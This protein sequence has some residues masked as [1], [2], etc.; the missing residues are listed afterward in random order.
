MGTAHVQLE[1]PVHDAIQAL[2]GLIRRKLGEEYIDQIELLQL[3]KEPQSNDMARID[4]HQGRIRIAGTSATSMGYALHKYL[5]ENVHIHLDWDN[6]TLPLP[7]KLPDV[8]QTI[9]LKKTSKVTYYLNVCTPSYSMWS[10]NWAHWEAHIDWMVLCGIN[11]PL[12]IVGQEKLWI[13]TFKKFGVGE[14]ELNEFIAGAAFLAWGRM[15][16]IQGSW[17]PF[18]TV[19]MHWIEAQ[20]KLQLLIL[21]RMRSFGMLPALPAFAGHVPAALKHLYPHASMRKA[22]QWAGF[23]EKYTCVYMLDPTDSLFHSIATTFLSLQREFY[24]DYTSS[25]YQT[26]MYNELLPHTSDVEYLHASAKAVID[27]MLT[28]DPNAVW[29]MQGW[30]FYFMRTFWTDEKIK[31]YLDGIPNAHMII[32]DLWSD[33]YPIWQR[34]KNYFGKS[35]IYCVLHT[36]GGNLGLHGNLP[37]LA[38]EPAS[39]LAASDG[40]MVGVG[41]TMEGIYQNYVVYE[42]V[43]DT[44]WTS[45]PIDLNPWIAQYLRHR[46]HICNANVKEGWKYLL[47]SVYDGKDGPR[48]LITYRPHWKMLHDKKMGVVD[49]VILAWK[50]FL[51][52]GNCN[53]VLKSTD[54]FLH[55]LVDIAREAL[56]GLMAKFYAEFRTL[57]N[58]SSLTTSKEL[59]DKK[60]AILTLL[61]DLDKLLATTQAFMLGRW[62]ADANSMAETSTKAYFEYQA[63]NQITRWGEGETLSDYAAKQWSGLISGYY[64][65]RWE[66]WLNAACNAFD[67]K[68]PMDEAKVNEQISTIEVAW[69]TSDEP[70]LNQPIGDAFDIAAALFNK[71]IVNQ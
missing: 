1:F 42:L 33:A 8:S 38:A 59:H 23:P 54:T 2:Q 29:L 57:F 3:K 49:Q 71:Y 62:L 58:H 30:L 14:E 55:D 56:S 13:E 69:Q 24:G 67:K 44:P 21:E 41:L 43:L 53:A 10:W 68:I 65:P 6:H 40:H 9:V 25:V 37:Q 7:L 17:G 52:A 26:D 27:S 60:D 48:C 47:S 50:C 11:M 34:T 18:G 39:S 45:Q 64:L 70:Y 63:R 22:S 12:A 61:F 28:I 16:N 32:L 20:S 31:A 35:W 15:G 36:F 4:M 66:C 19:P 46:Y 51:E 5:K